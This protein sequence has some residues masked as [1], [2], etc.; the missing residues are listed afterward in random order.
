[1]RFAVLTAS[2]TRT[3]ATDE[4]GRRIVELLEQAG[5]LVTSRQVVP[6]DLESLRSSA[7][8]TL[9]GGNVDVLVVTGGTGIAR[10]DQTPEAL[11]PLFEKTLE[12]FGELFRA[13]SAEAIG[14][15]A[16]LSRATAGI[17]LGRAVFLLPGS[18]AAVKLAVEEL[19][20]PVV[21]HLVG[22][23]GPPRSLRD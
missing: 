6:D 12:G 9:R 5:H 16:L 11:V 22:L 20:L 10:R 1:M 19:I 2:D 15:L 13:R 21:P 17:L 7:L 14:P 4:S 3:A 18:P 23:L 8:A